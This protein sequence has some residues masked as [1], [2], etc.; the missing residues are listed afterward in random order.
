M[1]F[2]VN[3]PLFCIVL[4]LICAVLSAVIGE[5]AAG[6]LT[7]ALSLLVAASSALVLILVL[8][9]RPGPIPWASTPIPGATSCSSGSWS[10]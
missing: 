2:A 10:P 8:R 7:R 1:S 3:L 6:I 9:D 5:R 4:S